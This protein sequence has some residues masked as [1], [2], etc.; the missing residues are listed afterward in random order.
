[1]QSNPASSRAGPHKRT[2]TRIIVYQQYL[3]FAAFFMAK[4]LMITFPGAA[5]ALM[6]DK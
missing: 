1:M 6:G 3:E 2:D 5:Y 4:N